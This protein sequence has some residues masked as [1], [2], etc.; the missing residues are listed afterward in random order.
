[1]EFTYNSNHVNRQKFQIMYLKI[2]PTI[3]I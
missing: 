1:M 3:C 2:V